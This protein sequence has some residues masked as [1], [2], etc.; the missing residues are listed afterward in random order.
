MGGIKVLK[1]D[2]FLDGE[3]GSIRVKKC[4]TI[5]EALDMIK[6]MHETFWRNDCYG[7]QVIGWT[8]RVSVEEVKE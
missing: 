7:D 2:V 4:D 1:F 3:D 5:Q 6:G 8:I